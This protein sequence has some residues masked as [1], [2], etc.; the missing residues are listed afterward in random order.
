MD[1][2]RESSIGL[3]LEPGRGKDKCIHLGPKSEAENDEDHQAPQRDAR[4]EEATSRARICIDA[5][6]G[7]TR[8]NGTSPRASNGG[9]CIGR[10]GKEEHGANTGRVHINYQ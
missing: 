5:E 10:G 9:H 2:S 7:P 8:S 3:A 4:H 6:E 1:K